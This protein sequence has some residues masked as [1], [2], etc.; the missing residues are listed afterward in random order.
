MI[1]YFAFGVLAGVVNTLM[2]QW[3][4]RKIQSKMPRAF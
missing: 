3:V 4:W 1:V 2:V